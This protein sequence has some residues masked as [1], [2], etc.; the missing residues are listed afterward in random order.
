MYEM[1]WGWEWV[2]DLE[3]VVADVVDLYDGRVA[4][5]EFRVEHA[6]ETSW[7]RNEDEFVSVEDASFYPKLD[8]T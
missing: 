2:R 4:L 5:A 8:V 6:F 7:S 3:D 1:W